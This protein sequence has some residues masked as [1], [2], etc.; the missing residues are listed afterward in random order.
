VGKRPGE[1]IA[2][3]SKFLTLVLR[4]EPQAIGLVLDAN[5]WAR[6]DELLEK[7]RAHGQPLTRDLLDTVVATSPKRRFAVSADGQRIRAS[8]GHSIDVDLG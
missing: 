4:H 7:S 5:G 1:A 8:Q 6:I 3:L 2:R